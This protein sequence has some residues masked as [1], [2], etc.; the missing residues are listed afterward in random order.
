MECIEPC[1]K[2]C[3]TNRIVSWCIVTAL[4]SKLTISDFKNQKMCTPWP[5]F[6]LSQLIVS[7]LVVSCLWRVHQGYN[8][9]CPWSI[10]SPAPPPLLLA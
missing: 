2:N 8:S 4:D 3:D 5:S 1:V 9:A 10:I 6:S 7:G